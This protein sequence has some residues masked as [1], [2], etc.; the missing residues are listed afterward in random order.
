[1]NLISSGNSEVEKIVKKIMLMLTD[2]ETNWDD[3]QKI[4]LKLQFKKKIQNGR[5][6]NDYIKTMLV[7]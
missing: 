4:K 5:R 6:T 7:D 2:R 1:M 3:Q